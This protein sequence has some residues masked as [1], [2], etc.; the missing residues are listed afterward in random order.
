MKSAKGLFAAVSLACICLFL[1]GPVFGGAVYMGDEGSSGANGRVYYSADGGDNWALSA[2]GSALGNSREVQSLAMDSAGTVYAGVTNSTSSAWPYKGEVYKK[3]SSGSWTKSASA[4][5]LGGAANIPAIELDIQGNIYLA[6]NCDTDTDGYHSYGEPM[7]IYESSD[8]GSSWNVILSTVGEIYDIHISTINGYMYAAVEDSQGGAIWS[9][10]GT[11]AGWSQ[12]ADRFAL[13]DISTWQPHHT[14][15]LGTDGSDIV[16]AATFNGDVYKYDV[17]Q[18]TNWVRAGTPAIFGIDQGTGSQYLSGLVACGSEIY[19]SRID[20]S[21]Q[22]YT[23]GY[24][25]VFKSDNKG[26]S[27][28]VSADSN[29]AG[30][31]FRNSRGVNS[32]AVDNGGNVFTGTEAD[33]Y[34]KLKGSSSWTVKIDTTGVVLSTDSFR[35]TALAAFLP[36][37]ISTFSTTVTNDIDNTKDQDVTITLPSG[38]VD[39]AI[40]ANTFASNVTLT[41]TAAILPAADRSSVK[42]SGIGIQITNSLG[43]Q[44]S[45]NVTITVNYRPSDIVG[46]DESSLVLARY[47]SANSIWVPLPSVVHTDVHQIVATTNHFSVFGVVQLVAAGNLSAVKVYPNPFKPRKHTQGMTIDNLTAT[48]DI[49]IFSVTGELVRKLSYTAQNGMAVWDGK[50]DSGSEVASGVYIAFIDS[51]SGKKKIKIVVER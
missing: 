27:W 2:E 47:D 48:A 15:L 30:A 50:N 34:K 32:I 9:S 25:G 22:P 26:L 28:T 23:D 20:L 11:G 40:P 12:F 29:T 38:N 14:R 6:V 5:A 8:G 10:T 3:T 33:V 35:V 13:G 44:P 51:P 31:T 24:A 41:I 4:S 49:K 42:L 19:V 17:S 7:R 45:R 18:S 36:P 21:G 43:L 1:T 37:L 46:L 39:V 16:Y